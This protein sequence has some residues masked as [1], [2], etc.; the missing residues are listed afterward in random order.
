MEVITMD[1]QWGPLTTGLVPD[2]GSGQYILLQ[3]SDTSSTVVYKSTRYTVESVQIAKATHSMW[4]LTD[5]GPTANTEDL[6]ITLVSTDTR[7][8]DSYI[9]IVLPILRGGSLEPAYLANIGATTT[10]AYDL[11]SCLPKKSGSE[12]GDVLFAVY[13]T[14]INGYTSRAE[15]QNVYVFVSTSGISVSNALM[16]RITADLRLDQGNTRRINTPYTFNYMTGGVTSQIDIPDFSKFITTTRYLT[17]TTTAKLVERRKD[18]A[19]QYKCMELDPDSQV[20]A[21]GN[22]IID[23]NNGEIKDHT[24]TDIMAERTILKQLVVPGTTDSATKRTVGTIIG[25]AT[26][27]LVLLVCV[28]GIWFYIYADA[29]ISK[30]YAYI[31]IVIFILLISATSVGLAGY[32]LNSG[33][34]TGASY[35]IAGVGALLLIVW[36]PLWWQASEKGAADAAAAADAIPG[37]VAAATAPAGSSFAEVIRKIP[38]YGVVAVVSLFGGFIIGSFY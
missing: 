2:T 8:R 16:N 26:A 6:I 3:K 24:L 29:S 17:D 9:I 37:G 23:V 21:N 11:G 10:P 25:Y 4:L 13:S 5:P 14:C 22:I 15:T 30:W 33:N 20:D 18:A 31:G 36:F 32:K 27:L 28:A 19:N 35:Y 38:V 34:L 12:A 1:F 7:S